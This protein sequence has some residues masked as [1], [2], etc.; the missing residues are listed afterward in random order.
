MVIDGGLFHGVQLWVNLPSNEKMIEP[1]Y[2]NLEADT[3]AMNT[4]A[5]LARAVEDFKAGRLGVVP[6]DGVRPYRGRP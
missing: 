1:A 6:P 3:V 5:E 2:Q 4:R